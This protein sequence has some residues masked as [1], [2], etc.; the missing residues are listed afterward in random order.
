M[1]LAAAIAGVTLSAAAQQPFAKGDKKADLTIG[2]G[3]IKFDKN[4]AT[5]DQHLTMEW[6]IASILND[7]T[8]GL[9]F[10]INNMYG[11]TYDG[12]TMGTYDYSYTSHTYGKKWN[13]SQQKWE[14]MDE[15]VKHKR[16]GYGEAD[17]KVSREDIDALLIASL[18]YS[19]ISNL[20]AY[21]RVG[22]GVG[23][24]N[25]IYSS[26]TN[27]KGFSD[28]NERSEH[29]SQFLETTTVYSYNDLDHVKWAG[30]PHAKLVPSMAAY[31]GATYYFTPNWGADMQIGIIDANFKGT[32]KGYPNSFGAFAV[33]VSYK[34]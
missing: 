17:M 27:L 9:G 21:V 6:G 10:A 29:K 33:G 22:L 20:D 2:V 8:V 25:V 12:H 11:A 31:V 30:K 3:T 24:M 26:Y 18:H 7:V 4:R 16:Q 23:V 34:F 19:P 13:Y 15:T 32:K 14:K 28:K 5:F 1:I